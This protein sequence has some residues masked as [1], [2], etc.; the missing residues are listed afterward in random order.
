MR[1]RWSVKNLP[2]VKGAPHKG[3]STMRVYLGVGCTCW[4]PHKEAR[5]HMREIFIHCNED[6][7]ESYV[8]F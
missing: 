8:S 2:C 6:V 7:G 5:S 3:V 4:G 1:A